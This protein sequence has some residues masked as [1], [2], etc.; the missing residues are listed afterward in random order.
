MKSRIGLVVL[1]Q[2]C[3]VSPKVLSLDSTLGFRLALDQK[4]GVLALLQS[5]LDTSDGSFFEGRLQGVVGRGFRFLWGM[6]TESQAPSP[7]PVFRSNHRPPPVK[8]VGKIALPENVDKVVSEMLNRQNQPK[9]PS[10]PGTRFIGYA[11]SECWKGGG[12]RLCFVS[13]CEGVLP[14]KALLGMEQNLLLQCLT[15]ILCVYLTDSS[16]CDFRPNRFRIFGRLRRV[17]SRFRKFSS[18]KK[19]ELL[20]LAQK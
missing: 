11:W 8:N 13:F 20:G 7:P 9:I 14:I 2:C 5:W 15:D 3:V 18:R 12:F 17:P 4:S 16:F 1:L 10:P 6:K 19:R